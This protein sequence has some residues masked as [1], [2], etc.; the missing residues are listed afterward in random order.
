[1]GY[2]P[3]EIE[4]LCKDIADAL[5]FSLPSQD[6][7][8]E[9]IESVLNGSK[10]AEDLRDFCPLFDTDTYTDLIVSGKDAE[11]IFDEIHNLTEC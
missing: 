2:D 9:L 5:P 11:D 3:D 6:E 1:M 4:Q 8:I 7:C 10:T